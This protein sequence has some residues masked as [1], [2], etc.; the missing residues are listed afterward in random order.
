MAPTLET[1]PCN[2]MPPPELQFDAQPSQAGPETGAVSEPHLVDLRPG[3]GDRLRLDVLTIPHDPVTVT[4][5]QP[6]PLPTAE[7]F[8]KI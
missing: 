8:V 6:E 7:R 2:N 1:G 4:I 3:V 5:S